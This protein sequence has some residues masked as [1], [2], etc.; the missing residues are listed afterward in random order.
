MQFEESAVYDTMRRRIGDERYNTLY[1]VIVMNV[2]A[3]VRM[4]QRQGIEYFRAA[5]FRTIDG[6]STLKRSANPSVREQAVTFCL[7]MREIFLAVEELAGSPAM[8][9]PPNPEDGHP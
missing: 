7:V 4:V 3:V 9:I 2:P 1:D 5:Y 6:Q 8:N